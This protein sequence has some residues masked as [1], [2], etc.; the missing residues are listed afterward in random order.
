MHTIQDVLER[1]T[2]LNESCNEIE[3]IY[4]EIHANG[5][6]ALMTDEKIEFEIFSDPDE[7]MQIF[8]DELPANN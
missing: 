2:K 6:G 3:N 4:I 5:S 7:L 8:E 1:L